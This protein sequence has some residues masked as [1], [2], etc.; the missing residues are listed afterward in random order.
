MNSLLN[1]RSSG[2]ILA[3][4]LA[5]TPTAFASKLI[6]REETP[7]LFGG[8]DLG[9]SDLSKVTV[10]EKAKSG[11]HLDLKG[12]AA[13]YREDWIFDL[14]VGWFN[15]NMS[16][17][18]SA[19]KVR[20]I[21]N[22]IFVEGSPRYRLDESWSV[23]PL[24]NWIFS[25]GTSFDERQQADD[26]VKSAFLAGLRVNWETWI[27]ESTLL[28]LGGH[29]LTDLNVKDRTLNIF[30]GDIQI[31]FP[32]GGGDSREPVARVAPR[33]QIAAAAPAKK[34]RPPVARVTAP[35][36]VT[37]SLGEELVLF[38]TAKWDV[39]PVYRNNLSRFATLLRERS[40]LW[41]GLKV[42]GHTDIRGR[43]ESNI[44]LS[45][46]RADAVRRV[47]VDEG[48]PSSKVD[49]QG[50]GPDRP[51][52]SAKTPEAYARNRRVEIQLTDVADPEKLSRE[53]SEGWEMSQGTSQAEPSEVPAP[54][55]KP[56][57][58][59]TTP[60]LSF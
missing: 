48:I 25:N 30:S 53:I 44:K 47:L 34:A 31:G 3:A 51:V 43:Y 14:G 55:V 23:G 28:R 12:V 26:P 35:R 13:F 54:N 5:L 7:W 4:Y 57:K 18:D 21:T 20:V 22:G 52:D 24:V 50:F 15:N 27:G 33:T 10:T 1:F 6:T 38:P 45:K 49:A 56:R 19:Y 46:N 42:E 41:G 59:S 29:W 11:Y 8:L 2:L 40:S 36:M 17:S 39:L 16:Y 9:Y 58:K 60:G 37:I 32:L